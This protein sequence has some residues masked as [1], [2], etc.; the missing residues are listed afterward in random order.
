MGGVWTGLGLRAGIGRNQNGIGMG[1]GLGVTGRDGMRPERG[2]VSSRDRARTKRGSTG[3]FLERSLE[4]N[5]SRGGAIG[6]GRRGT[7]DDRVGR[8]GSRETRVMMG[9]GRSRVGIGRGRSGRSDLAEK[10]RVGGVGAGARTERGS[11]NQFREGHWN[12]MDR[13]GGDDR[14]GRGTG[15]VIGRGRSGFGRAGTGPGIGEGDR[16]RSARDRGYEPGWDE[17]R[18]VTGRDGVRL[19]RGAGLERGREGRAGW[20]GWDRDY[21]PG[22]DEI[23]PDR[24][25]CRV[26]TGQGWNGDLQWEGRYMG[27]IRMGYGI[28]DR[29]G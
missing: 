4:W 13:E 19:G 27:K 16:A 6:G 26:G 11:T 20:G 29:V 9:Q 10:V 14:A 2:W 15:V 24:K 28:G 25:G 3:G 18:T 7:R 5:G 21:G 8:K 22:W 1:D 17:I 23:R 12:E